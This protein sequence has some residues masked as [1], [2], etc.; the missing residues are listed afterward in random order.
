[1]ATMTSWPFLLGTKLIF[2]I[3]RNHFAFLNALDHV[4]EHELFR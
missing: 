2:E 1:M 3:D 4:E